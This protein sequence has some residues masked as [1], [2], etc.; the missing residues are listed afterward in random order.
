VDKS[1]EKPHHHPK[2]KTQKTQKTKPPKNR[3]ELPTFS[4]TPQSQSPATAPPKPPTPR[5]LYKCQN[6]RQ[7]ND[8][9]K[10]HS[11]YTMLILS[12][13]KKL[14]YNKEVEREKRAEKVH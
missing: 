2:Q 6:H 5:S 7:K 11:T 9:S 4:A 13:E 10:T 3:G 8:F 12:D 14:T 1:D